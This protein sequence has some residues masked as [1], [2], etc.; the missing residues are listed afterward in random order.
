MNK[1]I[2]PAMANPIRFEKDVGDPEG[3]R[4]F[5]FDPHQGSFGTLYTYDNVDERGNYEQHGSLSGAIPINEGVTSTMLQHYWDATLV[6]RTQIRLD[7]G[8][9]DEMVQQQ[10]KPEDIDV[11]E[12]GQR[13]PFNAEAA[14]PQQESEGVMQQEWRDPQPTE[15][16]IIPVDIGD[17]IQTRDVIRAQGI[18]LTILTCLLKDKLEPDATEFKIIDELLSQ[19]ESAKGTIYEEQGD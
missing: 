9:D 13:Q 8:F 6:E 16:P 19:V 7:A 10:K 5:F 12:N 3:V 14:S 2:N 17:Y 11:I 18:A 1:S 15:M 4:E